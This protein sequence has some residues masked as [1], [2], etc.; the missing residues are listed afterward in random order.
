[1]CLKQC[2]CPAMGQPGEVTGALFHMDSNGK[3]SW[4]CAGTNQG[5]H[6]NFADVAAVSKPT[7]CHVT[8]SSRVV[9]VPLL[10]HASQ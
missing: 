2:N 9:M 10:C 4:G 7:L 8:S 6:L 1:M 3:W 5:Q